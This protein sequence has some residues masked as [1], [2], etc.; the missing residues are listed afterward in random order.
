M[1]ATYGFH[2]TMTAR[3]GKGDELVDVLLSA[4]TG[5]GP[6][7][8]ENCLLF[9]VG[10]SASNKDVVHVTDGWTTKEAHAEMFASEAAKA[11]LA[12]VGLEFVVKRR[13]GAGRGPCSGRPTA[14][15]SNRQMRPIHRLKP[16]HRRSQHAREQDRERDRHKYGLR[17][18]QDDHD[19]YTPGERHP[20]PQCLRP[21]YH[22]P[23]RATVL[24][25]VAPG[26]E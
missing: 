11:H 22:P 10:R 18:L 13:P 8:S 3:P 19:E 1:R 15:G 14:L 26:G 25:A 5:M 7:T 17:P 2:A 23:I 4:T 20:S 24:G 16:R 9:L 6:A 21:T 12:N